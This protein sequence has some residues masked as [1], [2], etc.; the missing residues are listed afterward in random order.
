MDG[1]NDQYLRSNG[2]CENAAR[3]DYCFHSKFIIIGHPQTHFTRTS[4]S[5]NSVI[6]SSE[7]DK[8]QNY[9]KETTCKK[10]QKI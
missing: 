9:V 8:K 5:C 4:P 3:G 6:L 1:P 10:H 2:T 7:S